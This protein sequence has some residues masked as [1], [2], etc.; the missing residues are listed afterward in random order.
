MV[1]AATGDVVERKPAEEAL[2]K[3]LATSEQALRELADQKFALDQHAVVAV[4]TSTA[5]S[6]LSTSSSA[7]SVNIQ[8]MNID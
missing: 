7:L 8:R 2:G 4:P 1:I 5:Q 6:L 3:S